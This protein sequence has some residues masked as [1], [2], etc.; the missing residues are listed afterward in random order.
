METQ[1]IIL[2]YDRNPNIRQLLKRELGEKGYKVRIAKTA[3]EVMKY[4]YWPTPVDVIVVDP[5]G[6]HFPIWKFINE[7][8][9][10]VALVPI[11]FH[12]FNVGEMQMFIKRMDT[13]FVEKRS[14]SIDSILEIVDGIFSKGK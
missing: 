11:I 13:F 14:N 7:L 1:K 3:Q 2:V 9:R 8:E 12:G 10:R 4:A 6:I 5:E